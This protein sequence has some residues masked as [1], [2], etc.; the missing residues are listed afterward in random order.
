MFCL[1]R[2]L[3]LFFFCA[4]VGQP[5]AAEQ[6][7]DLLD[8]PSGELL[9]VASDIYSPSAKKPIVSAARKEQAQDCYNRARLACEQDDVATAL[10]LA[11]RA[12]YLDPDH[13]DARRVLGYQ[14][15]GDSWAGSYAARRLK[16][17]E[18]WH[19]QFGW[20]AAEDL[21]RYEA[22]KRRFG[23]KWISAE[24]DIRRHATIDRGWQI[25]TDHFRVITNYR[26]KDASELALRLEV[27]YQLWQTNVC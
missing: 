16:K 26:R 14:R 1:L 4:S 9:F 24:E 22:G 20:I 27:L 2:L 5:V 17:G 19:Q 25:R 6:G 15:V 12:V 10:R 11:T 23:K 21:P 7:G 13:E 3:L 18:V 8:L